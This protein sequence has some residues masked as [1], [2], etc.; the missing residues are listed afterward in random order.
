MTC[1]LFVAVFSVHS[2]TVCVCVSTIDVLHGT[3]WMQQQQQQKIVRYTKRYEQK[4]WQRQRQWRRWRQ[5]KNKLLNE[6]KML[7]MNSREQKKLTMRRTRRKSLNIWC[8]PVHTQY[9]D[10]YI[11]LLLFLFGVSFA[12]ANSNDFCSLAQYMVLIYTLCHCCENKS[13][14]RF[15]ITIHI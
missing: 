10:I 8:D 14:T 3:T 5:T 11:Y 13:F 9:I 1:V 12:T 7:N 15:T 6:T 4:R 2:F